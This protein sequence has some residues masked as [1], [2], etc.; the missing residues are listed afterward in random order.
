MIEP[1]LHE[2]HMRFGG[3]FAVILLG[4]ADF[5]GDIFEKVGSF[6]PAV[7]F[8]RRFPE[9]LS[10]ENGARAEVLEASSHSQAPA[11]ELRESR[12]FKTPVRFQLA[13]IGFAKCI[14]PEGRMVISCDRG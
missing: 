4:N 5:R 2:N 9:E 14:R 6:F 3:L 7:R 12:A 11:R 13:I 10:R 8:A 1:L